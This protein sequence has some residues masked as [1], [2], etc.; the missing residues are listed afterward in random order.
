MSA[1]GA[2]GRPRQ[3]LMNP[4]PVVTDARVRDALSGPDICHREEEFTGLMLEVAQK[5]VTVADGDD[6]HAAVVLTGSGTAGLEATVGSVVPPEGRL[7]VLD[8]GHY[9][10]RLHR[11]ATTSGVPVRHLRLPAERPIDVAAVAQ[12]LNGPHRPSHVALVHHETSSGVLNPVGAISRVAHD[13][14]AQVMVDAI[15][16]FGAEQ[17]SLREDRIDWL[18]ASSNKCLEGSPGLAIVLGAREDFTSL[19]HDARSFYLDL[20]RHYE[21]QCVT[22][23]PAFTPA[24]PAFYALSVA[25]DLL[26]EETTAARRARYA[27]LAEVLRE[28][29]VST[30][31]RAPVP[32][33]GR[34]A[35]LTAF[36]LPAGLAY[37]T[38]HDEMK[39]RGFVI[40]GGQGVGQHDQFRISTMG[41]MTSTD[42]GDFLRAFQEIRE[43]C[44]P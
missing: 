24:V 4:G 7:L 33:A 17:I 10:D 37:A 42:I 26:I 1:V 27:R 15:S 2:G 13:V 23:A 28:G 16:S 11:I 12:E 44:S 32:E 30:G 40:Y 25:L 39:A 34:S 35:C 8:N 20:G 6:R 41:C 21:S 19:A 31:I 22:H 29:L 3:V 9:G 14:G 38:L 43:A 36:E 18:I 5:L